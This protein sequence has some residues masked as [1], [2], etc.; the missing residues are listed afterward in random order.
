MKR[1]VALF[2]ALFVAVLTTLSVSAQDDRSKVEFFG[3][4]SYLSTETGLDEVDPDIFDSRVG[5]HGFNTSLTGNV[6]RYVGIKGD[7]S[8]N[9]RT[10]D[11]T[12]G[13][14]TANLKFRTNQFLGGVQF[15]D[16]NKD[17]G[18]VKP[19]GHILAGVANQRVSG[20]VTSGG[21]TESDSL[22]TNN[23]AMVFGGG[24]DVR[25]NKR[26]DVRLFQFDFNPVFF[27]DQD[28]DFGTVQGR[29]QKNF[30]I[31]VGIVIH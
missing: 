16:N 3:G 6:S 1:L 2:F 20:S 24:V 22:S 7:F 23:F 30:R 12:N 26:V 18:R 17:A 5:S 25:V 9:Q 19:F 31:S 29:T 4:Y 15:K 21:V 27:K 10:W 11:V 28:T 14:D 8:W 13:T